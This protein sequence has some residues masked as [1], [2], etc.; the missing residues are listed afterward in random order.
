MLSLPSEEL[1]QK[2]IAVLGRDGI[3]KDEIEVEIAALAQEQMLVRRLIDWL[4][5]VFGIVLISHTVDIQLPDTFSA[6]DKHGNWFRLEFKLEPII[7]M[8]GK[9]ATEMYHA[10]PRNTFSNIAFRSAL[11]GAVNNAFNESGSFNGG[12]LSG[13]ALIGIPA[14]V[15]LPPSKPF[16][17]R[18]FK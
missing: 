1:L 8:A 10:G 18:F 4:P 2:A 6:Q 16:L 14:E 5:E 15:Y 12:Y 13:P 7:Q 11:L 3:S 17:Q 9:V